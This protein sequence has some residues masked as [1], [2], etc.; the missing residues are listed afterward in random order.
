MSQTL[1]LTF[2]N[3][4]K[5]S[6]VREIVSSGL[7]IQLADARLRQAKY[8]AECER[9]EEEYGMTSEQL[10]KGF[11]SGELGDDEYLFDWY[12]SKLAY[13]E[14]TRRVKILTGVS[15]AR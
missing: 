13:D 5:I 6:E 3:S 4:L 8:R 12:G 1:G 14:W 2:D 10:L 9:F 15:V 7:D 11:E